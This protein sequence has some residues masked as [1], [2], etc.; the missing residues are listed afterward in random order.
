M[1]DPRIDRRLLLGGMTLAATA[2]AS[3]AAAAP[4]SPP[5]AF[6]PTPLPFDPRA[7]PGLSEELLVSHHDNNYVGAVKRLGAIR[8][9]FG[10][11]DPAMAPV[12]MIN[13]LKREELLAWNSM[14]LHQIYFAGL[15]PPTAASAGLA[16]AVERDFGAWTS[17]RRSSRASARRL[18]A[19][20]AGCS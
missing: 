6:N 19:G 13:G 12:F 2:A 15:A 5:V 20:P 18:A 14:I 1:T 9:E 4:S 8:A 11:L 10:K 16:Q 3:A 17:G 7:V